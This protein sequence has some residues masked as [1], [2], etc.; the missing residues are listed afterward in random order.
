MI[1]VYRGVPYSTD[2]GIVREA[3]YRKVKET[4]RGIEH[5][6][7]IKVEVSKWIL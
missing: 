5:K 3:E 2:R 1:A 6:E 4:Y 7:I